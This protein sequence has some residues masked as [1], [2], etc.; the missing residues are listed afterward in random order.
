MADPWK[1][2]LFLFINY[3]AYPDVEQQSVLRIV[4]LLLLRDRVVQYVCDPSA[5][6]NGNTVPGSSSATRTPGSGNY[7]LSPSQLAGMDPVTSIP[8]YSGPVGPNP[9][10]LQYFNTY[11]LPNDFSQGDGFNTTGYR[12][13]APTKNTKN[14]YIAKMDYNLTRD[15]KQRLS[16]TGALANRESGQCALPA[17]TSAYHR[18]HF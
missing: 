4:P 14:W 1:R 10:V 2:R 9:T 7:V 6:C 13:A 15:G 8:G 16:L 17:G 18:L 11:P 3:E 5:T 12:F